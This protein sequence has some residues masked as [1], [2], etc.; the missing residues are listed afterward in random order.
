MSKAGSRMFTAVL[1]LDTTSGM[2][3]GSAPAAPR[4]H[5]FVKQALQPLVTLLL[6][7]LTKQE[8]GQDLDENIWN[9]SMAAGTCL[10]LVSNTVGNDIVPLTM[11]YIQVNCRRIT[12]PERSGPKCSTVPVCT[13]FLVAMWFVLL[14]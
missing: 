5:N 14:A 9:V 2:Q 13:S 10:A 1:L 8:E 7:Q 6:A 11:P 4:T 12:C 3:D